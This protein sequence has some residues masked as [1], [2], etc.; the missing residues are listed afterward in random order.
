MG[1]R[2]FTPNVSGQIQFTT[3]SGETQTR[4]L[5]RGETEV[6]ENE[7]AL[8]SFLV[9]LK[10]SPMGKDKGFDSE[11]TEK[12]DGMIDRC[13]GD[14]E[15]TDDAKRRVAPP[16]P[17][18]VEK[19]SET[20]SD[21]APPGGTETD[22][23]LN[24]P[25][26]ADSAGTVDREKAWSGEDDG[27]PLARQH[28]DPEQP[29]PMHDVR[30]NA[31]DR[32]VSREDVDEVVESVE[33][34]EPPAG[35]PHPDHGRDRRTDPMT[36]VD[37]VDVF[38]GRYVRSETDVTI[39]SRGFD[40]ELTRTYRSGPDYFGP[41]G[42]NW[43]HSYN[44]YL[45]PLDDGGAAVWTGRLAEHVYRPTAD[46]RLEPPTGVARRLEHE[47]ASGTREERYT[48]TD[49]EGRTRVFSRPDDW[50]HSERLPLVRIEDDAGNALGLTYDGQGR[51][52]TVT[53]DADRGLEFHY[54]DCG[55]LERVTDHTGRSWAYRH[56]PDAE[57]LVAV[58]RPTTE[59]HPDGPTI[60]YAYDES[61]D[62]PALQHNMTRVVDENGD[63]VLENEYGAD[64]ASDDFGR[65]VRQYFDGYRA[66]FSAE[67]L[68]AVPETSEAVNVPAWRVS[69]IDPGILTVYTFNYRGDLL[70]ERFRLSRDG[71]YRLVARTYRYDERGNLVERREPNGLGVE[72]TYD[73]EAD[74]PRGWANPLRRVLLAPPASGARDREILRATYEDR[75]QRPKRLTDEAGETT[76]FVYDYEV[77]TTD[78][79]SVVRTVYPDVTLPDGSIQSATERFEYDVHARVVATETPAGHR[80]EFTYHTSGPGEGL[81]A[82]MT[83]DVGGAAVER[84]YEYDQWG[85]PARM[86]DDRGESI[87]LEHDALARLVRR[88]EPAI[89]GD[90]ATTR[91]RYNPDGTVRRIETPRG[92]F[93]DD[94]IDDPFIAHEF[95]YDVLG[96]R[97]AEARGVNTAD[98]RWYRYE[99]DGEGNLLRVEDP[100]GTVTT[101][102]YDERG[103]PLE[104]TDAAESSDPATTQFVYDRTGNRT[105][106][107]DP[108]DRRTDVA[109]DPFDRPDRVRRPGQQD[110]RTT[111]EYEYGPNDRVTSVTVEG[112]PRP[113]D[114]RTTLSEV[115]RRYDERGRRHRRTVGGVTHTDWYDADGRVVKR[116]GPQGGE[117]TLAYDGLDRVTE[118]VDPAGNAHKATYAGDHGPASITAVDVAPDGSTETF[119]RTIVR[120]A[121]GRVTGETDPLGNTRTVEYDARSLAVGVELPDGTRV[122]TD[123][124]LSGNPVERTAAAGTSNAATHQWSRDGLGRVD[125]YVDPGGATTR[126]EYTPHGPV[127]RVEYDDG[128]E[129]RWSYRDGSVLDHETRPDGTRV[130]YGYDDAGRVAQ[131]SFNEGPTVASTP[132]LSV[133]FDG[134]DRP[135][136]TRQS[137]RTLER[138]YDERGR[139]VSTTVGGDTV[140]LAYD[141]TA[142]TADVTYPDGRVDRHRWDAAGRLT[143][144]TLRQ[145]GSASLTGSPSPGD[146]LVGYQYVGPDRP[147]RVTF[148][149]GATTTYGYD[150]G[151]RPT[152]VHHRNADGD[153]IA[154]LRYAYDAMGRRRVR[155][156]DSEPLTPTLYE[157]DELSRLIERATDVSADEPPV[158]TSQSDADSYI[159]GVSATASRR[160]E[161]F[162]VT[163]ADDRVER[164]V[165]DAGGT[166]KERFDVDDIHRVKSLDR[167][168]GGTT[169]GYRFDYSADGRLLADD[170]HEYVYDAMGR[171][172]EVRDPS[173]TTQATFEYDPGGRVR[174]RTVG[175]STERLTS[176]GSRTLQVDD[177]AGNPLRQRVFGAGTGGPVAESDGTTTWAHVDPRGSLVAASDENG[178]TSQRYDYSAFGVTS[179]YAP[180]GTTSRSPSAAVMTPRFAGHDLLGDTDLYPTPN[181]LYDPVTGRFTSR[182]PNG[183]RDSAS[184]YPYAANDPVNNI[185]PTGGSALAVVGIIAVGVGVGVLA[186]GGRQGIEIAMGRRESLNWGRI[187]TAGAVGGLLAPAFVVAPELAVPLAGYGV[188]QGGREISK[189]HYV[190]GAY[191]IGLSVLP[192]ATK[193][194]RAATIGRGTLFG[195]ARGLGPSKSLPARTKRL[196]GEEVVP[197]SKDRATHFTTEKGKKG[198]RESGVINESEGATGLKVA[199]E[200]RKSG[201]WVS[202]GS[203]KGMSAFQRLATGRFSYGRRHYVEFDVDPVTMERP[204][205]F[206]WLFSPAQRQIRGDVDLSGRTPTFG[207]LNHGWDPTLL[208]PPAASPEDTAEGLNDAVKGFD[209]LLSD[210]SIGTAHASTDESSDQ[211]VGSDRG[212]S[213]SGK[214]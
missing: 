178:R 106:T 8:L 144:I 77:S 16:N 36:A 118:R 194:G 76:E 170:R 189:G 197:S 91:Y 145:S 156:V 157:Y 203:A 105:A 29:M 181:R 186:E 27:R 193:G 86:T 116:V 85:T 72:T 79:G 195:K 133:D 131:L 92:E 137:G 84:S 151:R 153:T 61:R 142:G 199:S 66:E 11:D 162:A 175:G 44:Q 52:S 64:P 129:H 55:L 23:S 30:E 58:R 15:D 24:P 53:D 188:Y 93:D 78:H 22:E 119:R 164:T 177:T 161:R 100:E 124:D 28:R 141:D 57:Q 198:I 159:T 185:D 7:C 3:P 18:P 20:G 88:E 132:D 134:M 176:L 168:R 121:R 67:Q 17:A 190:T 65:V 19:P 48:L 113:G 200:G 40:I 191:D 80:H 122:E 114:P 87:D 196:V 32:G 167:T 136:E 184:P 205:G 9:A 97:T 2:T 214:K 143:A 138:R 202:P 112:V 43:D 90:R 60:C 14:R 101:A 12:I 71:S 45:R 59:E 54:G 104:R 56:G 1:Y 192:F 204:G 154:A 50:P 110:E 39:P 6:F 130:E 148:G 81:L 125:E 174:E 111:I 94:T 21:G 115:T 75:Y 63:V 103:Q 126:Y 49:R 165:D 210:L 152:T 211:G 99:H 123:Y 68:Q 34:N 35:E 206:K 5:K 82:S 212:S 51:L 149:N 102:A 117:T 10:Q 166:V 31:R 13:T 158:V 83:E 42:Y 89:D 108:A 155:H 140:S 182:D 163:V 69:V 171:V 173:G 180:D 41:F 213:G 109:Y 179:V 207:E 146:D 183:Y 128:S 70:D 38:G 95:E 120:D 47:P 172:V 33:R 135:V 160:R 4:T 187:G 127:T 201:V 98:P 73:T 46:G 25:S 26:G 37:P 107:I 147:A 74:D 209:D 62:H 139:V 96:R 208:T 169:T 150:A